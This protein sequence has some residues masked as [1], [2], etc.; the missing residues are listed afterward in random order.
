MDISIFTD[1][2]IIPNEEDLKFNIGKTFELWNNIIEY[3]HLKYPNS[4]DEWN[5]P[6]V[7][8]G[9]SFRLKDKKRAIVYLLP[10]KNYFKVA[11]VFGHKAFEM[12]M[13][14]NIDN[15]IKEELNAAKPY[16]EGRGIRIDIIDNNIINDIK[17]LIDVKLLN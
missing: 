11:F 8:Y 6:G 3:V 1:K 12:V 14:S 2:S 5:Y 15:K 17:T 13:Q 16:A 4:V 7:K 10:R 9:W